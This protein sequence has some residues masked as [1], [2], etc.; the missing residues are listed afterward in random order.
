MNSLSLRESGL[1]D[2]LDE[3]IRQAQ[4]MLSTLDLERDALRSGDAAGLNEAGA[5]KAKLV[6]TLET[7]EQERRQ[8]SAALQIELSSVDDQD[9]AFKWRELLELISEC[10]RRNQQNGSLVKARR[11]QV[12]N[13]LKAL[14][15]TE[16][17]LYGARGLEHMA[18][19]ARQFGSA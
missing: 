11:E 14:Q 13:V 1:I 9:A 19:G 17:E 15:G 8:L 6:E 10:R 18:H 2:V 12:V 5:G 3:Q 16:L 4:A 7:L